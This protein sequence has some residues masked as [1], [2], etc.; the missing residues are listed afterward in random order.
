[1]IQVQIP[2]LCHAGVNQKFPVTV[3]TR[4]IVLF[5]VQDF[6]DLSLL[7]SLATAFTPKFL[8]HRS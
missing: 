1:M 5:Q 2:D 4:K 3:K 6:L 7:L 8:A